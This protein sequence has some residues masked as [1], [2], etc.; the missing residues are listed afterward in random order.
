MK[1]CIGCKHLFE[2]HDGTTFCQEHWLEPVAVPDPYTFAIQ[3]EAR[4]KY[5]Q[6]KAFPMRVQRMREA[7]GPCGPEATLFAP[8]RICRFFDWVESLIRR[9]AGAK[10]TN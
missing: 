8:S 7:G 5:Q 4:S 6:G 2:R 9:Y 3:Y 1:P 10:Q